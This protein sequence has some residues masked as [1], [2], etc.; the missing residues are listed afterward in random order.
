MSV[1]HASRSNY[2]HEFE[3]NHAEKQVHAEGSAEMRY[4]LGQQIGEALPRYELRCKSAV[5]SLR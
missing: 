2:R 5:A 4:A 1:L 3:T